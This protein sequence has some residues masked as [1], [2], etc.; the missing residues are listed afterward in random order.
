MDA[1][2]GERVAKGLDLNIAGVQRLA[3]MSQEP[4]PLPVKIPPLILHGFTAT[5]CEEAR[6]I[7]IPTLPYRRSNPGE[8]RIPWNSPE[9][10]YRWPADVVR[11]G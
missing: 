11:G 6:I 10:P 3:A 5:A 7:N 8:C 2:Y 4:P 9:V 1:E